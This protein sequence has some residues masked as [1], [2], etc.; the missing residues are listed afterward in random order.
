MYNL[1]SGVKLELLPDQN[2][3]YEYAVQGDKEMKEVSN[4]LTTLTGIVVGYTQNTKTGKKV[5]NYLSGRKLFLGALRKDI[6]GN[7]GAL[8]HYLETNVIEAL[9]KISPKSL[10]K[11]GYKKLLPVLAKN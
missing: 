10:E 8:G 6:L 4:Y 11:S 2:A 3:F 7:E 5:V 1:M 9:E